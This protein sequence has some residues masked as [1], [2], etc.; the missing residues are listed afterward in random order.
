M[1]ARNTSDKGR[2]FSQEFRLEGGGWA[3]GDA[4]GYSTVVLNYRFAASTPVKNLKTSFVFNGGGGGGIRCV[5][6]FLLEIFDFARVS[7]VSRLSH[8]SRT[9]W[10]SHS[11][12]FPP[13]QKTHKQH[14]LQPNGFYRPE[15]TRCRLK[16]PELTS[17]CVLRGRSI[18]VYVS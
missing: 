5:S 8:L 18:Y 6:L 14:S 9:L 13:I 4:R 12:P 2:N 16:K 15:H 10:K 3:G 11:P 17:F 7:I 1:C